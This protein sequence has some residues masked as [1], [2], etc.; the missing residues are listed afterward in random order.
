VK[1]HKLPDVD[2]ITLDSTKELAATEAVLKRLLSNI[3][4]FKKIEEDSIR[5]RNILL[6]NQV[7]LKKD[8]AQKLMNISAET[9]QKERL[10]KIA[11]KSL[12]KETEEMKL[13]LNKQLTIEKQKNTFLQEKLAKTVQAFKK[14]DDDYKKIQRLN[15]KSIERLIFLEKKSLANQEVLEAKT[16]MMTLAFEKKMGELA[17]QHLDKEIDYKSRIDSLNKDLAKYYA[18]LKKSKQKYYMREKEL[19]EKLKEFLN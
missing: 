17:K 18:E 8:F 9:K 14:L 4:S 2:D 16:E 13:E 1:M 19:K 5:L 6:K 7:L 15:Q 3:E 12:L 11:H 10:A